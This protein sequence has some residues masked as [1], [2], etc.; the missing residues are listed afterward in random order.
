LKKKVLILSDIVGFKNTSWISQYL[1]YLSDSFEIT[2]LDINDLIETY[3]GNLDERYRK[4]I[5]KGMKEAVKSL[6]ISSTEYDVL[7]GFS[8]GGTILWKYKIN[9]NCS[10]DLICI[11]STRLRLEKTIPKGKNLLIFGDLD[12]SKPSIEWFNSH[13]LDTEIIKEKS[14]DLFKES[15]N[16]EFICQRIKSYVL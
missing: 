9:S 12:E 2:I 8:L 5:E 3:I 14:H 16:I 11:S 4:F 6:S 7:I 1:D 10:Q 15:G 13:N